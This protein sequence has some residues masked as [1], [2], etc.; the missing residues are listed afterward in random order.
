M[1]V[2]SGKCIHKYHGQVC[3]HLRDVKGQDQ[4]DRQKIK[5][6]HGRHHFSCPLPDALYPSD[7]HSSGNDHQRCSDKKFG[8]VDFKI[9][10]NKGRSFYAFGSNTNVDDD[11]CQLVGLEDRQTTD[12]SAQ[13]K[14]YRQRI[15]W[16]PQCFTDNIHRTALDFTR[17]ISSFIHHRQGAG[18]K[19]R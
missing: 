9:S 18:K 2:V 17:S 6:N 5:H 4:N 14:Q 15:P 13:T 7:D 1:I 3:R 8:R 12:R 16:T 10:N 19:V 11:L